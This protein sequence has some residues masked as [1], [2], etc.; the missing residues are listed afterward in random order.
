[1]LSL[2]LIPPQ[3]DNSTWLRTTFRPRSDSPPPV[4][5]HNAHQAHRLRQ[6]REE[7]KKAYN[8]RSPLSLLEQ[9]EASIMRR[10]G[11]IADFGATWIRPPGV[12]KTL[13][14]MHEEEIERQEQLEIERQEAGMRDLQ[15]QQ[16]LAEAQAQAEAQ[17]A[18]AAEEEEAGEA[19]EVDLDA[20]I[21]EADMTGA[22]VT[23]NE[24]SMMEGSQVETTEQ[25]T[26]EQGVEYAEMEE[27]ELTG[28]ARDEED[29]G[30]ERDLDDSVPEAGSYQHTDTEVEDT[31]SESELQNS[32]VG[33]TA[34]RAARTPLQRGQM[35]P[36]PIATGLQ[37]RMRQQVSAADAL[38]RSPGSLNLSSS[39]LDSSLVGS[40]PVMQR[41]NVG[42]RGRGGRSRR[43]RQS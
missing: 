12:P 23:F 36:P 17:E 13:Q 37:E 18:T 39:T 16:Q 4:N 19:V 32:F 5:G 6:Q 2:P 22:E 43:G 24:D 31:D 34:P 21:P 8:A 42:A 41:G 29:L 33:R 15:A 26:A 30:L 9:D 25:D 3:G 14:A 28:A 40:S 1:M 27:A 35:G 38:P 11:N 20:E 10:R 7:E